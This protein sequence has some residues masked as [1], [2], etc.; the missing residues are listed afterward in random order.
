MDKGGGSRGILLRAS[1]VDASRRAE[2]EGVWLRPWI[3]WSI[4][5]TLSLAS[6]YLGQVA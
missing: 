3:A 6:W 4:L 2:G 1:V 5:Q